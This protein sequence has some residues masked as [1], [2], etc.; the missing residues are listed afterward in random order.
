MDTKLL[1]GKKPRADDEEILAVVRYKP[2][3]R[4]EG[5]AMM[6]GIR[7]EAGE[8]YRGIR[9]HGLQ[10]FLRVTERLAGAG[11]VDELADVDGMRE[12][13]DAIFSKR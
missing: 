10:E 5:T 4:H 1:D 6:I 13:C 3:A 8:I 12:R 11:F 7:N 2:N 9:T